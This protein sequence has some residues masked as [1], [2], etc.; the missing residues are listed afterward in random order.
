MRYTLVAS[1]DTF[2]LNMQHRG[3]LSSHPDTAYPASA[4]IFKRFDPSWPILP[5]LRNPFPPP[6]IGKA[7]HA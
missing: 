3:I 2:A 5:A 6:S 1:N 7:G 4:L